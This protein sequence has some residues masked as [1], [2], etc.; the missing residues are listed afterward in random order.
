MAD[1]PLMKQYKEMKSQYS[2]M[3]LFFRLGDFYEMF[4]EDAK[5]V[6]ALLNLTLTHRGDSPMC[7][8]PYHAAKNY[9]K[10]LLDCG[11]KIAICEQ[12]ELSENSKALARRE[13][14]RIVTPA[15]VVD[16]D[17]LDDK[18]FNYIIC[19]FQYALAFCDVST[20]DF[21][22]RALDS[23][24]KVQAVRSV[25]QQLSPREIL[26]CEDEYFLDFDFKAAIDSYPAMVTKLAPWYFSQKGCYKILCEQAKAG[27][28]LRP[29][30][31]RGDRLQR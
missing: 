21:H 9:I 24:N 19:F 6:S 26:V 15:T 27:F 11:K 30:F 2:D 8:I 16:E 5:E 17:F 3:V 20:G 10:R 18:S 29:G 1:T 31:V 4:D 12:M 23:K 22:I 7:G 13:V 14:V 25:L 28:L